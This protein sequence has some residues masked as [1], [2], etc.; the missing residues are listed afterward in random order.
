MQLY[1]KAQRMGHHT[2]TLLITTKSDKGD[3]IMPEIN[4]HNFQ[5]FLK[6][7]RKNLNDMDFLIEQESIRLRK[8]NVLHEVMSKMCENLANQLEHQQ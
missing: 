1:K 5:Y 4:I 7:L 6:E 8:M 3:L 2:H